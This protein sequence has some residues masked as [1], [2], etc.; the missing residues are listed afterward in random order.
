[1]GAFPAEARLAATDDVP[2]GFPSKTRFPHPQSQPPLAQIPPK[3][4]RL[5]GCHRRRTKE[6]RNGSRPMNTATSHIPIACRV[7]PPDGNS[8]CSSAH[9]RVA[10]VHLRRVPNSAQWRLGP[11]LSHAVQVPSLY[12][13]HTVPPRQGI[14]FADP[15]N[16]EGP[17]PPRVPGTPPS[18]TSLPGRTTSF[19]GCESPHPTHD[20]SNNVFLCGSELIFPRPWGG[21][22]GDE[23]GREAQPAAQLQ[24]SHLGVAAPC[25]NPPWDQRGSNPRTKRAG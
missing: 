9:H 16:R 3:A 10:S 24:S 8:S 14:A 17:K 1:V 15:Q 4:R 19:T 2:P 7:A 21:P 13:I 11:F 12:K 5:P 23:T 22:R 25:A 20:V 6:Q 18:S